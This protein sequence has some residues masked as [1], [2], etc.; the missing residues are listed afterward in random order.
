MAPATA[1]V[2]VEDILQS[3]ARDVPTDP[4]TSNATNSGPPTEAEPRSHRPAIL[5]GVP[6][7]PLRT[8]GTHT[9][10]DDG[11]N[12]QT[13]PHQAA[14]MSDTRPPGRSGSC[15]TVRTLASA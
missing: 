9:N 11:W 15:R 4:S 3:V 7:T 10:R 2:S 14:C 13:R 8:T 1:P 6:A 5:R 12:A